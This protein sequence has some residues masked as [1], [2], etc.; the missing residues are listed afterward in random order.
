MSP[1][2]EVFLSHSSLFKSLKIP[3]LGF[4]AAAISGEAGGYG[5]G[6]ISENDALSLLS[7]ARERGIKLFDSA[8]IYGFGESERRLGKAFKSVRSEVFVISKCGVT[9]KSTK[10]VDMTN[11]PQVALEMLHQSLRDLRSD[12]IDLYMVHWPDAKV[13]IRH[14]LEP[15]VRAQEAGKIRY[16]GLCNT[17]SEE[18][19]LAQEVAKIEAV[20]NQL[21]LFERGAVDFIKELHEAQISF[22]SWGTFDKGILTSRVKESRTFDRSDCR[23]WA[24]WWK[25]MDKGPRYQAMVE[26]E[27]LLERHGHT[28]VELALA[29]NLSVTGVDAVLCGMKNSEQL[30][31]A[32]SAITRPVSQDLIEQALEIAAHYIKSA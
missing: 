21:N 9:W 13:D 32:H 10:R 19:A 31:S 12:Y 2:K 25:A 23:S 5:F 6:N 11:D 4:G 3:K 27:R 28:S 20:Q 30:A 17:N 1:V 14:T 18:L 8:P 22:M 7:E 16:L 24:P 29:H 26:I 15:L